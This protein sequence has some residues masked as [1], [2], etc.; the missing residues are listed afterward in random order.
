MKSRIGAPNFHRS[1]ATT[2]NRK[3][4]ATMA[5]MMKTG[6]DSPVQPETMVMT[7]KGK[8]VMPGDQHRPG[9]VMVEALGKNRG[10]LGLAVE[11]E[12]RL[13]H[14]IPQDRTDEIAEKPAEHRCDEGDRRRSARPATGV[15]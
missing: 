9:A 11:F 2:K 12:D 10:G 15:R 14:R 4:R 3:P 7:L 5:E 1:P 8:G 6:S 13:A